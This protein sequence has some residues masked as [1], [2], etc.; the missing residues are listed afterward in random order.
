MLAE[1]PVVIRDRHA[2]R[3]VG[4]HHLLG[5]D[6][7]E[8]V[9]VG[10]ESE[11]FGHAADF[12]VDL[13]DQFEGPF[14]L[15]GQG[16][17]GTV[18]GDPVA[19][20]RRGH[21]GRRDDFLHGKVGVVVG[22]LRILFPQVLR[23]PVGDLHVRVVLDLG[24]DGVVE[25]LPAQH[26]VVVPIVAVG[27]LR[28][29]A[30]PA[31]GAVA[32]LDDLVE[33]VQGRRH[34]GAARFARMKEFFLVHFGRGRVVAD[35]DHLDL[36][37]HAL[38]EQVQ[39]D[40]EAFGRV[41]AGFVHRT[42]D[43]HDAE[44][45]GLRHRLG[46][47]DAVAVAQV[48]R[49]DVRDGQQPRSEVM[50][51]L[52]QF[53]HQDRIVRLGLRLVEQRLQR[54]FRLGQPLAR[55]AADG[56]A[57]PQRAAQRAQHVDVGGRAGN[58]VAG[59]L[60]LEF[61]G[62]RELG[63][64]QVGQLEILEEII[65]ELFTRQFEDEIVLGHLVAIAGLAAA[66]A[67]AA[68]GPVELVALLIFLVAGADG[69][70]HA[71]MGV[72]ERWLAHVL[73][74]DRDFLAAFNVGDGA[75]LDGAP[76]RVLDL[77]FVTAQET[78]AVDRR[79]VFALQTSVD[80]VSQKMPPWFGAGGPVALR[81]LAHPQ[82]PFAQQAH[83]L[84][85]I[86]F[87]H[88]ARDEVGVL[89]GVLGT[90]LGVERDYRQQFLRVREHL[91]LDHG[92][93]FLVAGP[94]RVLA[95]IISAR[96]QPEVDNLVAEVFRVR[97]AGRL[98][99][100]FQLV[101]QR[102]AVETLA[103]I[104]IA[105]F[106]V[107]D[108][109]VGKG[110]VAIKNVLAVFR[111]T[112][113]V[114]GL[115]FLADEFDIALGQVF[116][117]IR[118]IFLLR[119][120]RELFALDLLLEHIQQVHRIGGHLGVVEVKD[121]GQDL[122]GEA[123]GQPVHAF[124]H[125]RIVDI[126]VHRLGLGV[127]VLEVFAVVHQHLAEDAGVFRV[128][129]ARQDGELRHHAQGARRAWR[130]C[131]RR[132][133]QQ[134]VVNLD[135]VVDAQAVRHLDDVDP[136]QERFVVAV[137][138]EGFPFRFVR[139]GQDDAVERNGAKALGPL[140][141]AFLR[142]SEQR[143]QHLD[144]RL[145]HFDEFHQALVGQ[146][147]PARIAV[148]I[149]IVLRI[150]LELADVDLADQRRDILVVFV[151]R[152]GLGNGDLFQDRRVALDHAE[153]VDVA[154]EFVQALD[155]PRAGNIAQ[156][157]ARYA[158]VF[159]EDDAVFFL[160][161]QAQRG[162]VDGRA[163][164]AIERHVF[165]QR[166]ELFRD[167]RLA[168]ADRAQ[169]VKDLLAFFQPL[170]RVAEIG[171]DLLDHFLGAVK[172]AE[173]G[174]DLDDLVGE[175]ARQTGVV[176]GIDQGRFA[177][178]SEHAFGRAG[179]ATGSC[180]RVARIA[181]GAELNLSPVD[182]LYV[183]VVMLLT[184]MKFIIAL[185]R[186]GRHAQGRTAHPYRGLARA[187]ADLRA[188]RAQRRH[189]A[190][191][192]GRRA[193]RGIRVHRP[194]IVPRHLL[195]G[196]QRAAAR[197]GFLR[198]DRRLPAARRSRQ[199]APCRVVF[200]SANPYRARRADQG[201]D[202]RHPPRLPGQPGQRHADPEL[203]APPVGRRR[204]CHAGSGAA[205]SRQ[206][207][208]HRPRFVRARQPAGKICPRV[209]ALQG[210]GLPPGGPCRRGRP[211][212][213]YRNGARPAA[214][215]AHR[216][217]R[218]LPGR[219]GAGAAAGARADGA[220]RVP[221]VQHQAVRVSR[222]G[223]A[224]PDGTAR[225]RHQG[226]HQLRRPRV[227]WRL[228]ERQLHCHLRSVAAGSVACASPQPQCLRGGLPAGC[229]KA[230]VPG[231]SRRLF[232]RR[233]NHD[234]T[235]PE[236][237]GAR[238]ARRPA[239]LPADRPDGGVAGRGRG[240]QH[241]F[242][243]ASRVACR[244]DQA[245]ADCDRYRGLPQHGV[246]RRGRTVAIGA[247]VAQG[248]GTGL[249]AARPAQAQHRCGQGRTERRR[250][251][252]RHSRAGHG[253][254]GC[255]A[256]GQPGRQAR[257]PGAP[258][259]PGVYGHATD[260]IGTGPRRQFPGVRAARDA[261]A[262]G[263]ARHQ[264]G[265]ARL[266]R[267][268]PPAG[269]R[270]AGQQGR[271]S[272]GGGVPDMDAGRHRTREPQGRAGGVA[273]KRPPRNAGRHGR[274]PL[275]GPSPRRVRHAA[276]PGPDP[277]PGHGHV[278]V[279][280]LTGGAG[281]QRDGRGGGLRRPLCA[282][283]GA[284]QAGVGRF[285]GTEPL[286]RAAGAGHRHPAAGCVCAAADFAAAQ[287]A[288]QPRDPARAGCAAGGGAG[289]LRH[290][291]CRFC[292]AAAV[293]GGRPHAGAVHGARLRRRVWRVRP[294]G[295]AGLEGAQAAA[296]RHRPSK[297]ALCHHLAATASRRHHRAGGVAGAGH[298][299]AAGADRG[300]TGPD[301]GLAQRHAGRCAQPLHHQYPAR[302]KKCYCR[303]AQGSRRGGRAAVSD[304]PRPPGGRQRQAGRQ[305]DRGRPVVPGRARRGR[306][307]GGGG[308]RQDPALEGGR[309]AQLQY[310]R[311]AGGRDDH[312]LA[313]ARMGIDAG[314]F[315]CHH[316][317][318]GADGRIA[319]LDHRIPPAGPAGPGHERPHARLPQ[320]NRRR[321]GRPAAPGAG[322]AR[323]GRH[324]HRIP[325]HLYT[326]VGS[327]GAADRIHAGG[328]AG[329]RAGRHR[330]SRHGLG[331]GHVPVQVRL[332]LL[333]VGMDGGPGGRRRV[334]D[335]RRLAGPA[336]RAAPAAVADLARRLAGLRCLR[337][338][339]RQRPA[340]AAAGG[341]ALAVPVVADAARIHAVVAGVGKERQHAPRQ[342]RVEQ[343]LR[344]VAVA[345]HLVL[346]GHARLGFDQHQLRAAEFIQ[347]QD[348]GRIREEV[349][350][351]EP[352][353][354]L[355]A[356]HLLRQRRVAE[357]VV[358]VQ[359]DQLAQGFGPVLE[360]APLQRR[361]FQFQG[362]ERLAVAFLDV[363]VDQAP[364]EGGDGN[365]FVGRAGKQDF[366]ARQVM[367][368]F[369][370]LQP[371]HLRH[372]I[373]DHQHR[374][375][376]KALRI[377]GDA[378][379]VLEIERHAER[380]RG[381]EVH[382]QRHVVLRAAAPQPLERAQGVVKRLAGMQGIELERQ[383]AQEGVAVIDQ[384]GA[385]ARD[386][387]DAGVPRFHDFLAQRQADAGAVV[388]RE[389]IKAVENQR[390]VLGRDAAAGIDEQQARR[391]VAAVDH[392][393]HA[394][395]AGALDGLE[396]VAQQI[397]QDHYRQLGL[398]GKPEI[399]AHLERHQFLLAGV[400]ERVAL[401]H[402]FHHRLHRHCLD[403]PQ[404]A[405]HGRRAEQE[406]IDHVVHMAHFELDAGQRVD[407]AQPVG[408]QGA[409]AVRAHAHQ[410]AHIGVHAGERGAQLVRHG[411]QPGAEAGQFFL[412]QH[413][414]ADLGGSQHG[415]CEPV[416]GQLLQRLA[417][418]G[419]RP[420]AHDGGCRHGQR[421]ADHVGLER[422]AG[423][424]VKQH[425]Q[426]DQ[427]RLAPHARG[428][429]HQKHIGEEER[430]DVAERHQQVPVE[431]AAAELAREQANG[432]QHDAHQPQRQAFVFLW[433]KMLPDDV[434]QRHGHRADAGQQQDPHVVASWQRFA[435]L[436][437]LSSPGF[438]THSGVSNRQLM[439]IN[440]F[441][442]VCLKFRRTAGAPA[443]RAR[444]TLHARIRD[445]AH[446]RP[447]RHPH[448]AAARR[449][450][451]A[452]VATDAARC[453]VFSGERLPVPVG[454]AVAGAGPGQRAAGQRR[455]AADVCRLPAGGQR[456]APARAQVRPF[457][458]R[459]GQHPR[460]IGLG[461]ERGPGAN[462]G[463]A[464]RARL[465]RPAGARVVVGRRAVGRRQRAG[466]PSQRHRPSAASGG[467]PRTG[468]DRGRCAVQHQRQRGAA[469]RAGRY[470]L[471]AWLRAGG[472]R[473]AFAG[474]ARAPRRRTG[475]GAG[476]AGP[477]D[478]AAR[479]A[480]R[481][482]LQ[483]QRR[484]RA[485]HRAGSGAG[486]EDAGAAQAARTARRLWRH[487]LRTGHAQEPLAGAAHA[488]FR[489]G[490]HADAPHR[491]RLRRYPCPGR[492]RQLVVHPPPAPAGAGVTAPGDASVD[493]V[494]Q[495]A[496]A[497][498]LR[499]RSLP[500][501]RQCAPVHV[502]LGLDGRPRFV[503]GGARPSAP[504]HAPYAVCH[505]H[506]GT[507]PVAALHGM[508][509]GGRG[510]RHRTAG[511]PDELLLPDRRL[512]AQQARLI[513]DSI[514]DIHPILCTA[515]GAGG[516]GP[517]AA[518]ATVTPARSRGPRRCGC[519]CRP[520]RPG[521]T[522]RARG[523]R[524]AGAAANHRASHPCVHRPAVRRHAPPARNPGSGG[525]RRTDA[526]PQAVCR[527]HEP[528]AGPA[529][530]IER[531]P[532]GRGAR[533]AGGQDQGPAGRQRR[534]ARRDAQDGGREAA[535]HAGVA[536]VGVV[537]AG[538]GAART[539]A[540]GTGRDAAAGAG[541]AHARAVREKR[542]DHCRQRRARGVCAQAAGPSRRRPAGVDADRRQV[543]EGAVRTAAGSG[544]PRGRR[545]RGAGR[546]RAR[547]R[548]A[549][550]SQDHLRKIRLA[551]AHHR[552]RHPVPAHRGAVRGSDAPSGPG[553]R[554]AARAP[555]QHC[556]AVHPERA[557]QQPA[558][559]LSH[560]GAGKTVVGSV[561]GA[562]RG[563]DGIRQI[564]RRAGRHQAHARAGGQEHRIGGNPQPA[565]G[566]QAQIGG[567]AAERGGAIAAGRGNRS[568]G[569]CSV[570]G[571]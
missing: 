410:A 107:L 491:R 139:V 525:A 553:R 385:L 208:R 197:A 568:A 134:L 210:A 188:G 135:L 72:A 302:A 246:C 549:R 518:A 226:H 444:G 368:P 279:R 419:N 319:K 103:R 256:A 290:R 158:V 337:A 467:A 232:R 145:E 171:H 27:R 400:D 514:H 217:W 28:H 285:A 495:A 550:R 233:L 36:V 397:E 287:G 154:V 160:V 488:Q 213:L 483:C 317:S 93:E 345:R 81:R 205:V 29:V 449:R 5:R 109:E 301:D 480:G 22:H 557:A 9:G 416:D 243:G 4:V 218:T 355:E 330:R 156:V 482:R 349:M 227:F 2:D 571:I 247:G 541:R 83:L 260:R 305:R 271:R 170:R 492:R 300:A 163:F 229:A 258:R 329:R 70:P 201:R 473:I 85:R 79:L 184:S 55:I 292:H 476:A 425:D 31:A 336:Q 332:D 175:D 129:Q 67:A 277:E 497:A 398:A 73:D 111:V 142:G 447:L 362:V 283:R 289:H 64:D 523:A 389:R 421:R 116:L 40:E 122:E 284:G 485:D 186:A 346:R 427:Q 19:R 370:E 49:V 352:H 432:A 367:Q 516:R 565:N 141:I 189:A 326:G 164:Q 225:R 555:H 115:D 335:C 270:A 396:R 409:A 231:R 100:F 316:Q 193:A 466:V 102:F 414:T 391:R 455:R 443:G 404:A 561:A 415:N 379:D 343:R 424:E 136:V 235:R 503:P 119:L 536:P 89:V 509:D 402:G 45:H 341:T 211:A 403:R 21:I 437:D 177:D 344:G 454:R 51:Q 214:C 123:R 146:A 293:A 310:R 448:R 252:Q 239:A 56:N 179:V 504:A 280:I 554:A 98:F 470:R 334:R 390:H 92:A 212:R 150:I 451:S 276:L 236:H 80:E 251:R 169:Q 551:A 87:F 384:H 190:L 43:V 95:P 133:G 215:R 373:I 408:R 435:G 203:P 377:A 413:V 363:A 167:R 50:D 296:R 121:L 196:R 359:H 380:V 469:A 348:A 35:E 88:H 105:E 360:I 147:Q 306:G 137:V 312:Q 152:L 471:A 388:R 224:Q 126:F 558:D 273:G 534:P 340:R 490:P 96:P 91:L 253:V 17:G 535:R 453:G 405:P 436:R 44:H 272:P 209:C 438:A 101:V 524:S 161:E 521:R 502:S 24:H 393:T 114:R 12:A 369:A 62:G 342:Q 364:V 533:H 456:P 543:P 522:H 132:V 548:G 431:H 242:A 254:D 331:A 78:L 322:S 33:Q 6:D 475:G 261:V 131:Q 560:A 130:G 291:L 513:P 143:M 532:H 354:L 460:T 181:R 392:N 486:T 26:R 487:V 500:R 499:A 464:R 517:A 440:W 569:S 38:E 264:P 358:I 249:S 288:A 428:M 58:I 570:S 537:P 429:I 75:P 374:G 441:W 37:V 74:G 13:L 238:L 351:D 527:Q 268:V 479:G 426:A 166:L 228:H 323:P 60:V 412:G 230:A 223:P 57:P 353:F 461:R 106:L 20:A 125:A 350:L 494:H 18:L 198:H 382:M 108:P 423:I 321:R 540:P 406:Q 501:Q 452:R 52:A 248:R 187:R 320:F 34:H 59:T 506:P 185:L 128:F 303:P 90:G 493:A 489:P 69:F 174:V 71:A 311:L 94:R 117:D 420:L 53:R 474:H 515:A 559:G 127:G 439:C 366:L 178:G 519:R 165:H 10:V 457:H 244:S 207:H 538:V 3:R 564:R 450:T 144:R 15:L 328:R 61:G 222:H 562:R 529:H 304:D 220:D 365:L 394:A 433:E 99:D 508:G 241:R 182:G 383:T 124:V 157:A 30:V 387:A 176:A 468:R 371:V 16:V 112:F 172:F 199:R 507:R 265:P 308:H 153:L 299:G 445:T 47:L 149:G 552:F 237:D 378:V 250:R 510:H 138:T 417:A 434:V 267:D 7:L 307:I 477:G 459:R 297:L 183:L 180:V 298:D 1:R 200:R 339:V 8:L 46:H 442:I 54:V 104:G 542:G 216:P 376:G 463:R 266:P 375:R 547:T 262:A 204:V 41:L 526:Q 151:A 401:E 76:H 195:R 356:L 418:G 65:H 159:F 347:K 333:A 520:G 162:L 458:G 446:G 295:V 528:D 465:S 313:Q 546:A 399:A 86:A 563:E 42:G 257:R 324:G 32:L 315:L 39:Q 545:W 318:G 23:R 496:R 327:A 338:V 259:R 48:E 544:R 281:R 234:Q 531:R 77:R 566:A 269:G 282:A 430:E 82:V 191:S 422:H 148:G 286:A 192:V 25:Q 484:Q 395:L 275:H 263:P 411:G 155:G 221:A 118:Q 168:A 294:G 240:G 481:A 505:R 357:K 245:R 567:S 194:A 11:V 386:A 512:D 407:R 325:V 498:A 66:G 140:V 539:R 120:G 173:G 478:G 556:R 113:Q 97:D 68:L 472:R 361:D 255:R 309:Q 372:R 381:I 14:R 206:V 314:Q 110:H 530:R 511:A 462:A 274:A 202:R 278:F 219:P 84:G 63:L